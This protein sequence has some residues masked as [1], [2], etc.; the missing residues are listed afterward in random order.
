MIATT[1]GMVPV[2]QPWRPTFT[3]PPQPGRDCPAC[4]CDRMAHTSWG[5]GCGCQMS[6]VY[7]TAR[8]R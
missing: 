3:N 1:A 7:L 8:P 4:V 5:C 2:V 6:I